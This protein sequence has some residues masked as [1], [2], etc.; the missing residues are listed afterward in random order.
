MLVLIPYFIVDPVLRARFTAS[1]AYLP[2]TAALDPARGAAATI[3]WTLATLALAALVLHR[4]D[5]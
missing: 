4:R 1:A 5:A 2:D 3:V